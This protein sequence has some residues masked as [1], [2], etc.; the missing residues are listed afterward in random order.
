MSDTGAAA[1]REAMLGLWGE[2]LEVFRARLKA[3]KKGQLSASYM[4]TVTAFLA[5]SGIS[6][7]TADEAKEALDDLATAALIREIELASQ[8]IDQVPRVSSSKPT[9][10]TAGAPLDQ[11]FA[12]RPPTR[13]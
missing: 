9:T 11:P 6:A 13:P 2:T 12:P 4:Q 3:D 1:R 7:E 8:A 5:Q 10:A